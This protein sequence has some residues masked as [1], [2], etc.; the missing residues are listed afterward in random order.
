MMGKNHTK[1]KD[2]NK[3]RFPNHPDF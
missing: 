3:Q 2:E 1:T